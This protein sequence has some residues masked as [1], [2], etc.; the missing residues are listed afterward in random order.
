LQRLAVIDVVGLSQSLIGSDTPRIA[1]FSA[2]GRL[3]RVRPTFPA[4]TC[5]AQSTYLTGSTPSTHGIVGNGWYNREFAEVQFWK[6]SNH[7]VHGT[8]IWEEMRQRD[9][10][11]TCAKLFWWYNMYSTADYSITPRPIY[12]A[13]GRKVFDIY[14]S[15]GSIRFTIKKD[16]GEFPFPAFWGPAAGRKTPQADADAVSKWIAGSA[17]WIEEHHRPTL[18]LI[19]LPHLDYNLQRR[20][21]GAV[22]EDL[23]E[24]DSIVGDLI[25][26]FAARSIQFVLLSEYGISKVEMPIHLNRL[27]REKN[28]ITIR[29]ELGRELLDCGA[30]AVFAVA[31]HQI[32]HIYINDASIKGEVRKVLERT[33]GIEQ[34]LGPEEKRRL[35]IDHPRAGDFVAVAKENAWFTYFYWEDDELAPDFARTVDIHRKPGYDPV[36][37]FLDPAMK[38]PGAK[39]AWRLLQKKLGFRMLMD[40]IPL[41]ASLVK[42]SHGRCPKRIEEYPVLITEAA[43]LI[44]AAEIDSTD[45][46]HVLK[47]HLTA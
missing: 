9:P 23:H 43:S 24:I 47:R 8:K 32:A 40:V 26:Y 30:S 46:Y 41:D 2:R 1:A 44:S 11:F 16:L 10:G 12:P 34:V 14:T 45:V 35:G 20:G 29:Q 33:D 36:E 7:L 17:K 18:S 42:G 13:D 15:P 27:F 21:P 37:L 5:S 31:D 19:Y 4:V 3:A 39:I 6:Q 28:W 22:R 25:D 38:F